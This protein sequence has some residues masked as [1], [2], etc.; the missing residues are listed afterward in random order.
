MFAFLALAIFELRMIHKKPDKQWY[1]AREM[2]EAIKSLVWRY[3]AKDNTFSDELDVDVSFAEKLRD[4]KENYRHLTLVP[5]VSSGSPITRWMVDTRKSDLQTRKKTYLQYRLLDQ[6]EWYGKKVRE[7][8]RFEGFWSRALIGVCFLGVGCAML[9]ITGALAVDVLGVIG[10]VATSILAWTQSQHFA[11]LAHE[12]SV[13]RSNLELLLPKF[14]NVD[15][16]S[17][18]RLIDDVEDEL[19]REHAAWQKQQRRPKVG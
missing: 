3:A 19:A 13:T 17:W 11:S 15:E 18:P 2:T 1:D 12:Y 14:N 10:T 5:K 8:E 4:L 9:E 16:S 6:I 7:N